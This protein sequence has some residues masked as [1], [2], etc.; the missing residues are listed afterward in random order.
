MMFLK[1]AGRLLLLQNAWD[2]QGNSGQE[3]AK[4]WN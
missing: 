2:E 4:V 1:I 3:N